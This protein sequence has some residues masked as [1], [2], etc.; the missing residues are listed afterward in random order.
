M[1]ALQLATA[2]ARM[3]ELEKR[4]AGQSQRALK[5]KQRKQKE[6]ERELERRWRKKYGKRKD[7][8]NYSDSDDG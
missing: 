8:G 3:N 5:E 2:Q 1:K 7:T 4:A 6:R